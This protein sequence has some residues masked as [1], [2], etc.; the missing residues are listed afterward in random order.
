MLIQTETYRRKPFDV[1]AIRVTAENMDDVAAW[2]DGNVYSSVKGGLAKHIKVRVNQ[3]RNERQTQAFVGD[4]VLY[5][6]NGGYKVFTDTAFHKTF[7]P[8]RKLNQKLEKKIDKMVRDITGYE[9]VDETLVG[10]NC[11]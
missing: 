10:P 11:D 9:S 7:D 6:S 2:C 1:E 8:L 4:W 3:A 5:A